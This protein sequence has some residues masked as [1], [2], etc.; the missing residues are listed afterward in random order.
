MARGN[1][2]RSYDRYAQEAAP[3]CC[4]AERSKIARPALSYHSILLRLC[5]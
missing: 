1:R 3:R 2:P 5:P 4:L